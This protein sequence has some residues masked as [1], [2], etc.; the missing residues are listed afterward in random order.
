MQARDPTERYAAVGD[1]MIGLIEAS[2]NR[3]DATAR[4]LVQGLHVAG[5]KFMDRN[6]PSNG[7]CGVHI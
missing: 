2:L 5:I 3:K 4:L 7:R 1:P 6:K